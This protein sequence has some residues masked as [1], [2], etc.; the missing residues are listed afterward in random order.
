L[1]DDTI[2]YKY[3]LA[4]LNSKLLSF[5]KTKNSGSA[6]KDDFTQITLGDI[7]QLPIPKIGSSK[8][9][10]FIK[11]VDEILT[12]KEKYKDTTIAENEIDQMV[13]Q[14]FELTEDEIK[15]IETT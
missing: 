14:L 12:A 1:N 2:N 15:I 6:K 9:Q 4:L 7:R 5:Y 10:K 11:L 3:V 13:Y 8:Q